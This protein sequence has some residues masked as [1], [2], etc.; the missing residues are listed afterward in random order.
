M[1]P[2]TLSSLA[3]LVSKALQAQ[4]VDSEALFRE[5]GLDPQALKKPDARYP[6]EGMQR[7]WALAVEATGDEGIGLSVIEYWHP[8]SMHA[9][10][11][12]WLAS[13]TLKEAMERLV[14]YVRIVSTAATF[15]LQ[16]T[17]EGFVL[18]MTGAPPGWVPLPQ[19]IDVGV[20]LVVHMC[21][22]SYGEA[23][24]PLRVTL[25]RPRPQRTEPY[26]RLFRAPIAYQAERNTLLLS[27]ESLLKT[28]PT[29][30]T[31]LAHANEKVI[32][33]YLANLDLDDIVLRVK[34]CLIDMLPSGEVS[35]DAVAQALHLSPRSLQRKLQEQGLTYSQVLE[36]TR[37]ELAVRYIRDSK[38][39]ISEITF[40][41]GFSEPSNFSR[42][43][44]RW[45][46]VSP[47]EYRMA[48]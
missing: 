3:L 4:G 26:E 31:D 23:F 35:G 19:S 12:A 47:S 29:G 1:Y 11:F 16:E 24:A 46:G 13:T 37:R 39:S 38:L 28:L 27:K 40:M 48:S 2:T 32:T 42:A 36:E 9:L 17:H 20:A 21:R 10:G 14:R 44:K 30:N 6:A 15:S 22:V 25:R 34:T 33:E 8:T 18:E 5:A 43:F 7:L 45:N 41:L